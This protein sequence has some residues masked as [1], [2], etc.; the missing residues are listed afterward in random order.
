MFKIEKRVKVNSKPLPV[1]C[2]CETC[3]DYGIGLVLEDPLCPAR[4][5]ARTRNFD[6]TLVLPARLFK[7]KTVRL[8]RRASRLEILGLLPSQLSRERHR[9]VATS[10]K[11]S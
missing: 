10:A 2:E 5:L 6:W 7:V 8:I 4:P 9:G 3:E 1:A 11:M